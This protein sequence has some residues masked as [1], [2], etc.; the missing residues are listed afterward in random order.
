MTI[1]VDRHRVCDRLTERASGGPVREKRL[2][3]RRDRFRGGTES[4]FVTRKRTDDLRAEFAEVP[5]LYP[6]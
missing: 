4:F 5:D 3:I 6:F 1:T 2:V